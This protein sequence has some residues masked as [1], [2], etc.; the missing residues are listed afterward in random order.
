[1]VPK[2]N[3]LDPSVEPTDAE[4]EALMRAMARGVRKKSAKLKRAQNTV[5]DRTLGRRS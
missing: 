5:L 1:M 3:L 2:V 4:L